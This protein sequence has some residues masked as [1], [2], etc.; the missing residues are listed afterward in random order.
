MRHYLAT[1]LRR[2][3]DKL[4]PDDLVT[5]T[6]TDGS[7][8]VTHHSSYRAKPMFSRGHGISDI[9]QTNEVMKRYAENLAAMELGE[10]LIPTPPD[11]PPGY[12][13]R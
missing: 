11:D 4:Y 1:L 12:T 7:G 3:A 9:D 8:K 6:I 10:P 5:M 13:L 2:L